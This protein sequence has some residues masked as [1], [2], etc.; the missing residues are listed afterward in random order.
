MNAPQIVRPDWPAPDSVQAVCTTRQ[1]GA[2]QP[3]FASL[4]LGTN[5]GDDPAAVTANRQRLEN[6]LGLP[7][8]PSWLNQQHGDM[9][10]RLDQPSAG[11]LADAAVTGKPEIVLAVLTAD[12]LPV[13]VCDR[14]GTQVAAIHAGWRG[15]AAGILPAALS[16]LPPV[17]DLIAW[18]GPAI[19]RNAYEVGLD[20]RQAITAAIPGS[21]EYFHPCSADHWLADLPGVARAQLAAMGVGEILGGSVC[22]YSDEENWFSHRRD[23]RTGRMATL[24]WLDA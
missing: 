12:C 13:L 18:L 5:T 1:G 9:V 17:P 8:S 16:C 19:G 22:T 6:L 2:S 23:G 4:N 14:S 21:E 24:I 10:V 3:P 15:L 7:S 20:V 11:S